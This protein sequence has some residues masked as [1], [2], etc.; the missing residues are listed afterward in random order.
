MDNIGTTL[1][2][3]IIKISY[4]KNMYSVLVTTESKSLK[5]TDINY[6]A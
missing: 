3:S 4:I 2:V 6:M 5:L 1:E